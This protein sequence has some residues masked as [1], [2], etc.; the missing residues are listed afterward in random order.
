MDYNGSLIE[1][2]KKINK[3]PKKIS[4]FGKKQGLYDQDRKRLMSRLYHI[5]AR[6]IVSRDDTG[7][8]PRPTPPPMSRNVF[9][10]TSGKAMLV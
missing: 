9:Y 2:P 6:N 8:A 7:P 3:F 10:Q 1:F 4:D 5:T